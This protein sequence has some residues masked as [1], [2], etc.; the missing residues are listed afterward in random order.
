MKASSGTL[1][2]REAARP[3]NGLS[4]DVDRTG[5]QPLVVTSPT[6]FSYSGT[7]IHFIADSHGAIAHFLMRSVEGDDRYD[8]RKE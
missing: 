8:R 5:P 3:G 6:L 4:I 1:S 2:G 7:E